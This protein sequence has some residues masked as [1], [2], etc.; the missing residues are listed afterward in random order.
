[1]FLEPLSTTQSLPHRSRNN[2]MIKE[3]FTTNILEKKGRLLV[4]D[5]SDNLL[6]FR[7]RKQQ[8]RRRPQFRGHYQE[9]LIVRKS[10]S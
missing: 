3:L 9:L 2:L 6:F 7:E 10:F 8:G 5:R 4:F 1:M